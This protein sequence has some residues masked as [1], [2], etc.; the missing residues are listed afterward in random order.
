VEEVRRWSLSWFGRI[1][2]APTDL[3]FG[4][5]TA[6]GALVPLVDDRAEAESV[7]FSCGPSNPCDACVVV[8]DW[9]F[10]SLDQRGVFLPHF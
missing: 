2:L 6:L 9:C 4:C 10:F 7:C 5:L 1:G 8:R 3:S